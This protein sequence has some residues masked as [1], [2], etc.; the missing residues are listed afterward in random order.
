MKTPTD[1]IIGGLIL[2]ALIASLGVLLLPILAIYLLFFNK[3]D[4]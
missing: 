1:F 2:G 4:N 3:S